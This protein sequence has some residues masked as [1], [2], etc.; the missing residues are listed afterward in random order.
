MPDP[1]DQTLEKI[2]A[3]PDPAPSNDDLFVVD[4]MRRV[5][6][7]RRT[8]R[9][10]LA[11]FGGIGAIFGLIGAVL[12]SEGISNLFTN[13]VSAITLAQIPL[14]AAGAAAFY[15]WFMNDDFALGS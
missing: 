9:L 6:K 8:R 10:I 14:F 11:L 3:Y 13:T 2:L 12:L 5:R 7:E 1:I 4:V 15:I